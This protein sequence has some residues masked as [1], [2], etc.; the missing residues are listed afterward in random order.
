MKQMN[1]QT[2][3]HTNKQTN[4]QPGYPSASLLLTSEKAV[5]CNTFSLKLF[6]FLQTVLRKLGGDTTHR[7][8]GRKSIADPSM[9]ISLFQMCLEFHKNKVKNIKT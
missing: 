6:F 2:Y 8:E 3:K 9:N 7:R 5:F 1:K 4:E